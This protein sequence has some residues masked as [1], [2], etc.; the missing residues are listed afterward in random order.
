[1]NE[2]GFCRKQSRPDFKVLSLHLLGGTEETH[3]N[4]NQNSRSPVRELKPG[5]PDYEAGML[6]TQPRRS[7]YIW[8]YCTEK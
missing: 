2:K 7:V 8:G 6:T 3:E 5:P 4:L 1:M